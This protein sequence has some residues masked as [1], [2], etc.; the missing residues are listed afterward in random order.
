MVSKEQVSETKSTTAD[1]KEVL[2]GDS[3]NGIETAAMRAVAAE[4]DF[5]PNRDPEL[6]RQMLEANEQPDQPDSLFAPPT[7]PRVKIDGC[8]AGTVLFQHIGEQ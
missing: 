6:T 3:L 1:L 8:R 7:G 4:L 2:A 5:D